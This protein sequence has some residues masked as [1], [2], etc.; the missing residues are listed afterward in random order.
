MNTSW[1]EIHL[2]LRHLSPDELRRI[3]K[4]TRA[5]D[6][7]LW[8][9]DRAFATLGETVDPQPEGTSLLV[10]LNPTRLTPLLRKFDAL[11]AFFLQSCREITGKRARSRGRACACE[12]AAT[13]MR[14]AS[15]AIRVWLSDIDRVAAKQR[16]RIEDLKS[17]RR[18]PKP[19]E[20]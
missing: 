17:L 6:R 2:V 4:V 16:A 13:D 9:S 14:R 19:E 5:I 1:S 3:A 15:T 20:L 11:A 7:A 18:I 8:S 10:I 12:K